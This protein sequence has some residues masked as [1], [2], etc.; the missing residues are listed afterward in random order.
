MANDVLLAIESEPAPAMLPAGLLG[1]V[2]LV[3]G[4]AAL[5]V[6]FAESGGGE[7]GALVGWGVV[8]TWARRFL[9]P[10]FVAPQV[11]VHFDVAILRSPARP[12]R[13]LHPAGTAWQQRRGVR[14]VQAAQVDGED[15]VVPSHGGPD[16]QHHQNAKNTPST[17]ADLV[18][19]RTHSAK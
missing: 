14:Q 16:G 6:E 3:I 8:A 15:T 4:T 17:M 18:L 10:G 2:A 19:Q 12:R 13:C 11:S 1:G 9:D 5:L 7:E